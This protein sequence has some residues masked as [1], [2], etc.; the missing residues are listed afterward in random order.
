MENE[1]IEL[2]DTK[3]DRICQNGNNSVVLFSE[4]Y[5][6]RSVGRAGIDP[7]TVWIRSAT[8]TFK[9]GVI[10]GTLP[11]LPLRISEGVIQIGNNE[12]SNAISLPL[13]CAGDVYLSLQFE[14]GTKVTISGKSSTLVFTGTEQYL[15]Q[16]K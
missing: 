13:D 16:F 14:N 8:I 11:I 4:A 12:S 15:E 2:H 1:I 6:H 7:G 3:V 5:I 10:T 9:D